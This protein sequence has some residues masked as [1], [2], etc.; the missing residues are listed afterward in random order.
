MTTINF[1]S[2]SDSSSSSDND[3]SLTK[4]SM[5]DPLKD[6]LL[7]TE[8]CSGVSLIVSSM[9][10]A[11]KCSL[12][13]LPSGRCYIR[14]DREKRHDQIVND[15]FKGE[16]SKYT[17]QLFR[18]RFRMN[19]ELFTQILQDV[20]NYDSYFRQKID[21]V[22]NIGLSPLQ[23]MVAAIRMLAYGCPADLLD[24]YIQIGET[25]SIESLK[26]F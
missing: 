5:H 10:S 14:R 26:H 6:F 2:D 24:E 13:G 16:N 7:N 4:Q 8:G 3:L 23:K 1:E 9:V 11:A 12:E 20:E 21:A 18:R 17:P 19:I 22:G 25:T 15:Y